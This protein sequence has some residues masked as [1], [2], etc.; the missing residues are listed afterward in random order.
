MLTNYKISY[1][2]IFLFCMIGVSCQQEE[3]EIITP[4]NEETIVAN[5][6]LALLLLKTSL[7]DGSHDDI[8][9]NASCIEINLPVSV[10]VNGELIVINTLDD[11]SLVEENISS[12]DTDDDIIEISFPITITL[13]DHT[14][15]DVAN[16]EELL[17]Y[18]I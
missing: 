10:I 2:L 15:V 17:Q 8:L 13:S 7:N 3:S 16:E 18:V 5:S 1:I 11:I 14:V 9:D 4:D 6:N 12:S